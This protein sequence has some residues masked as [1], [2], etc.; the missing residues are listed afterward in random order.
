MRDQKSQVEKS[1][2][3]S[4][5]QSLVRDVM[6]TAKEYSRISKDSAFYYYSKALLLSHEYHEE[7]VKPEIFYRLA[8]LYEDATDLKMSAIYLDSALNS[9]RKL[10]NYEWISNSYNA[11]GDLKFSVLDSFH[12]K[13]FF[14]SAYAIATRYSLQQQLGISLANLAKFEKNSEEIV[15]K[16]NSAARILDG[17]H[18]SGREVG[19]IYV[20]LGYVFSDPDSVLKYSEL[21]VS[22]GMEFHSPE[23]Q[24]AGYNNMAYSYLEKKQYD[25]AE[26]C[27]KKYAIPLAQST[28]DFDWLATLYDTYAD[29]YSSTNKHLDAFLIERQALQCRKKAD[30]AKS[31]EQVQLLSS[32]LDLKNK[33]LLI[34]KKE[35]EI[36]QKDK[37]NRD[38][39]FWGS[40]IILVLSGIAS[41]LIWRQQRNKIRIQGELILS[42]KR[43]ISMEENLKSRV[44]MELHDLVTPFYNSMLQQLELAGINNAR[45]E[46]EIKAKVTEFVKALR[47]MSHYM[48]SNFLEQ[49]TLS[50]LLK[51]LCND[52]SKTTSLNIKFSSNVNDKFTNE[53]TIHL[54]RVSQELLANAFKYAINSNITISLTKDQKTLFLMYADTGPGFDA[55]TQNKSGIGTRTIMERIKLINGNAILNTSLGAGTEWTITVPIMTT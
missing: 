23:V 18:R 3:Q 49:L 20:N 11:L 29:V 46:D 12:A 28:Q 25:K 41:I 35:S 10:N 30:E 47:D 39:L 38:L 42:A 24:I 37:A 13:Q 52:F 16:L 45:V 50:E 54:Y 40:A 15:E 6:K 31:L 51:G 48:H 19:M 5:R 1:E 2:L 27:L 32:L 8:M 4:V 7:K 22:K 34:Q 26:E 53:V 33:E 14:D 21:A 36:H 9:A 17:T 44:S 55:F 43:L